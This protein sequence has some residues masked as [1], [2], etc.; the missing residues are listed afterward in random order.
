MNIKKFDLIF[1]IDDDEATN[2]YH[3]IVLE[4][5][6]VCQDCKFFEKALDALDYLKNPSSNTPQIIFLDINMP[7]IDGW[8]FLDKYKEIELTNP[9]KIIMFSTSISPSEK[10]KAE[11]HPLI[12]KY[13]KKPLTED[14]LKQLVKEIV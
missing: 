5:A 8:L 10:E 4:E 1:F 9:P 13:L 11:E 7:R 3:K 12:Y 6:N 14:V 2:F